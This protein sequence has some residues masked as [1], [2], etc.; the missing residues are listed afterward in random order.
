MGHS[1]MLLAVAGLTPQEIESRTA[2][3]A[4]GDWSEFP[5]AERVAYR[6]ARLLTAE[7]WSVTDQDVGR[8]KDAF[9]EIR[10]LD[11]VWQVAWCNYMTRVADAFQLSLESTNVFEQEE[12]P[13]KEKPKKKTAAGKGKRQ[14]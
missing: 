11:L 8:L 1:E 4:D 13:A 5:P 14:K 7:P 6:F 12:R 9:G 10:A 2:G 3:L